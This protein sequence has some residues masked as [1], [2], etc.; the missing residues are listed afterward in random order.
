MP[1]ARCPTLKLQ[2]CHSSGNSPG[3]NPS[4]RWHW[5]LL[6]RTR[7]CLLRKGLWLVNL[8]PASSLVDQPSGVPDCSPFSPYMVGVVQLVEHRIVV[9]SVAGSSPVTH[10]IRL[11]AR[12]PERP[13]RPFAFDFRIL[14]C[15]QAV[16]HGTLTPAFAGSSPAI[17]ATLLSRARPCGAHK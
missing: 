11:K 17:P 1:L 12:G 3:C 6:T 15:S 7:L 9:P 13:L 10:P 5:A 2:A 16:R 14:G 8:P 4:S